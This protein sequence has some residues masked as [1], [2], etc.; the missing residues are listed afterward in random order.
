MK[1]ALISSPILS[2][3]VGEGEFILDTDASGHGVGAVLSQKRGDT[4]KA[5]AYFSRVFRKSEKNYC[6]TR[7]ELLT[8]VDADKFFHH[9]LYKRRFIIRT[10][11]FFTVDSF[12]SK[13]RRATSQ[14]ARTLAAIRFCDLL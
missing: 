6:I 12:L 1:E 14:V 7:R 11:Y 2:F 10:P 4:E 3:P 9:Y 5:I 13:F 8:V